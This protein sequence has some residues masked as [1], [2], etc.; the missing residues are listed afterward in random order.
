VREF[1]AE[2]FLDLEVAIV[3]V[4]GVELAEVFDDISGFEVD[5][6]DLVIVTTTF[7]RRPFDN[8]ASGATGSVLTTETRTAQRKNG[9][10]TG[11]LIFEF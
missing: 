11:I 5:P 6:F 1:V 9:A 2:E 7:D 8:R 10:T 4:G 3:L